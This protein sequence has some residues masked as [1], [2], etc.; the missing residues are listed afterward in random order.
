MRARKPFQAF[1]A[2]QAFE[3]IAKT[4]K[5]LSVAVR[6][7][8]YSVEIKGFPPYPAPA[9]PALPPTPRGMSAFS[10]GGQGGE[11][12]RAAPRPRGWG[13]HAAALGWAEGWAFMRRYQSPVE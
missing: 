9:S 12:G 13:N 8:R 5:R 7:M 4:M 11:Q 1:H 2:R 3:I 6:F 10:P